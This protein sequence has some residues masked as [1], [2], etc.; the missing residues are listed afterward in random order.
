MHS[1]ALTDD[2]QVE[3]RDGQ[4]EGIGLSDVGD[5]VEG[6]KNGDQHHEL[7]QR[8][9]ALGQIVR[10]LHNGDEVRRPQRHVHACK[11]DLQLHRAE[12]KLR[13]RKHKKIWVLIKHNGVEENNLPEIPEGMSAKEYGLELSGLVFFEFAVMHAAQPSA[14]IRVTLLIEKGISQYAQNI[15]KA[16]MT[17]HHTKRSS[18]SVLARSSAAE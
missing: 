5:A 8:L 17:N 13:E 15:I 18:T 9:R 10:V 1:D 4:N 16:A 12:K 14:R 6:D 3:L 2:F 7:E 11:H